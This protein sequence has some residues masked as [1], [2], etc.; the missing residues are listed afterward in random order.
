MGEG[1]VLKEQLG[2]V[3][4][5]LDRGDDS[6]DEWGSSDSRKSLKAE[7]KGSTTKIT[8][9]LKARGMKGFCLF[10][11]FQYI[12]RWKYGLA[13]DGGQGVWVQ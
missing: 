13:T 4:V 2:A 3:T 7:P 5:I 8:V 9:E 10:L 1:G 12:C 6:L 11:C